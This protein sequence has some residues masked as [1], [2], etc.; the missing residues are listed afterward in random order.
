[1]P[2]R[3]KT[4]LSL[5]AFVAVNATK[6][7][8]LCIAVGIVFCLRM[9]F[10][11]ADDNIPAELEGIQIDNK[12][13]TWLPKDIR[14]IDIN[15]QEVSLEQLLNT[16]KP[17]I[18][19][20]GYY[21][22]PMLCSL[23]LNGLLN[24]LRGLGFTAGQDFNII[25]VTINPNEGVAL[26]AQ[27]QKNY[28]HELD[29]YQGERAWQFFVGTQAQVSLL[30]KAVG[31]NY[32]YDEKT[33]QYAHAAGIFVLT[34]EGRLSRTLYGIDYPAKDLRLALIEAGQG[35]LGSVVDRLLLFCY[36]YDPQG[37]KYVLYAM[38][39]MRVAGVLTVVFLASI[40][41]YWFKQEKRGKKP[42]KLNALI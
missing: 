21:E 35:K 41:I 13:G 14:L 9:G 10:V 34:K 42:S 6:W 15:Q 8:L 33:K 26:A 31:F 27:K 28:L 32:R 30:A 12:I 16:A 20:L 17:T 18:L 22:C 11:A 38:N 7:C 24:G 23:V 37:R 2:Q 19:T 40:V 1:M 29:R 4:L 39:L 5:R 3:N 25:S 36:H